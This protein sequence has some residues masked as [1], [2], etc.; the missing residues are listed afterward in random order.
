MLFM[1]ITDQN[2]KLSSTVPDHWQDVL[3]GGIVGLVLSYFAYRQYY[4]S[5]A[6]P[7]SHRP[8]SPR[9]KNHE[10]EGTSPRPLRH[11]TFREVE[12]GRAEDHDDVLE[13]DGTVNRGGEPLEETWRQGRHGDNAGK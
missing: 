6:S 1:P 8:Y 12:E 2:S 5:L 4:P 7:Y 9:I 13:M 10:T 11:D 3:V